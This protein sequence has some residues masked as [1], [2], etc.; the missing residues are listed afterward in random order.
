MRLKTAIIIDYLKIDIRRLNI[1]IITQTN[2]DAIHKLP[3][4]YEKKHVIALISKIL[5]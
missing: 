5:T 2:F 1:C 4:K 3:S